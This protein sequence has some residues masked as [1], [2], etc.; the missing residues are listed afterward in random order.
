[1]E[2]EISVSKVFTISI[3]SNVTLIPMTLYIPGSM[4]TD[5][6]RKPVKYSLARSSRHTSDTSSKLR[7]DARP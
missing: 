6:D 1:M 4:R 3:L 2:N 7:R 5:I